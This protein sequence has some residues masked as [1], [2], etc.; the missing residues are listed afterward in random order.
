[1]GELNK[2]YL[3][4]LFATAKKWLSSKR[5]SIYLYCVAIATFIWFLMKFSGS[6]STQL[7]VQVNLSA[8]SSQW[9]VVNND[10]SLNVD[11]KGFGFSIIWHRISGISEIN[12]DLSD[13]EIRGGEIDPFIVVPTN[14]LLNEVEKLFSEDESVDGIYPNV[15]KVDLSHALKKKV[16]INSRIT[17]ITE[18]GYKISNRPSIYPDKIELSGPAYI[19]SNIS[20]VN[21]VVDTLRG[22]EEDQ[23]Y[24]V[25]LDIDTLMEWV[26]TIPDTE[27]KIEVDEYTSGT[28]DVRVQGITD[29]SNSSIKI[30]PTKV[31]VYY[32]VG[33]KDYQLV[34]EDLFKAYVK[35]PKDGELPDKL[36]VN[37]SDIPDFVEITRIDPPYVEYLLSKTP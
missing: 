22:L 5:F 36:K 31:S 1:M 28:I 15:L 20:K 23:V 37:I 35:F 4:K 17:L 30:L 24:S 25:K 3:N 9:Y 16:P 21:T 10:A 26:T 18:N 2:E 33:L 27:L 8:P 11:V 13:F 32:Q 29:D 7:P 6:F 34:N 19:L 14:F 12:I